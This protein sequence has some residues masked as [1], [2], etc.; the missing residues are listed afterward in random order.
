[1]ATFPALPFGQNQYQLSLTLAGL[2][3]NCFDPMR[4][5]LMKDTALAE[6]DTL[7][8]KAR[9]QRSDNQRQFNKPRIVRVE[10]YALYIEAVEAGGLGGV[11]PITLWTPDDVMYKDGTITLKGET[12]LSANDGETQLAARYLLANKDPGKWM[13]MPFAATLTAACTQANAQQTLH[14]MNHYANPVSEKE[15]AAINQNGKLT[16]A[17]CEGV[18]TS[19]RFQSE[20]KARGEKVTT[21]F[22]STNT[23]CLHG[24]I[25]ANF[26][27]EAM[28]RSPN[29]L[30]K[31]GNAQFGTLENPEIVAGFISKVLRLPNDQLAGITSDHMMALG[32]KY[33]LTGHLAQPLSPEVYAMVDAQL[34]DAREGRRATI[35]NRAEAIVSR[36]N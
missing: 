26:G 17:I 6:A 21:G 11:P 36:L 19:G 15:T 32:I 5:A 14:D 34:R 9:A 8:H 25:G 28:T 7:T 1:M 10:K 12:I 3:T 30:I 2:G 22:I 16:A 35:Q 31:I 24:A 29:A 20:I 18:A 13:D 23:I 4:I 27:S 33:H